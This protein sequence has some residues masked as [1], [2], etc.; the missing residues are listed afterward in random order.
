VA[1]TG[2]LHVKRG[3]QSLKKSGIA[4]F[5]SCVEARPIREKVGE[6]KKMSENKNIETTIIY[7]IMHCTVNC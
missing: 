3:R 2:Q 7:S 6:R 1:G 4:C 5:L